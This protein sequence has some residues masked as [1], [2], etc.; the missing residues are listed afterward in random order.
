MVVA[1]L[2]GVLRVFAFAWRVDPHVRFGGEVF[3]AGVTLRLAGLGAIEESRCAAGVAVTM[4]R[5]WNLAPAESDAGFAVNRSSGACWPFA[6][7]L[8]KQRGGL[9]IEQ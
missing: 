2:V 8:V 1:E 4:R 6:R 5:K 7:L 9:L 3:A